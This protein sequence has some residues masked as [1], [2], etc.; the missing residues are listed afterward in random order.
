MSTTIV[1]DTNVIINALL[2]GSC[3]PIIEAIIKKRFCLALS[4]PLIEEII[5]VSKRP[6]FRNRIDEE[7]RENLLAII[8][9]AA[10]IVTPKIKI[11]DCRDKDDNIILECAIA[12]NAQIIISKDTD[13]LVLT[14]YRN[15]PIITPE[16][17]LKQLGKE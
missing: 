17:L 13:L 12:G 7:D 5:E 9:E 3:R 4:K 14:P 6:K 15:I 8:K 16:E 10:K 2:K 1:I 11:T